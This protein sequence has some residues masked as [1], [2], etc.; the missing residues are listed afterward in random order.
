MSEVKYSGTGAGGGHICIIP[1]PACG[2][3][4]PLMDLTHQLLLRGLT[5]T[6]MVTPKNLSYLNPLLALHSPNVKPLVF[7]FPSHPSLPHGVEQMQDLP[8]S[9]LP[10]IVNALG[11]LYHPLVQWFRAQQSPPVAILSDIVLSSW[12]VNLASHLNIPNICFVP[13][14]VAA[15]YFWISTPSFLLPFYREA[16]TMSMQSEGLVFNSFKELE[17]T[18]LGLIKEKFAKHCRVW[19]VGPLPPVK[20]GDEGLN[21]RGGATSIPPDQVISWLDSCKVDKSVVYI[22]FGTQ[23]TLTKHQMKAVA[24]ALEESGVRFIWAVKEPMKRAE[25]GDDDQSLIPHGFEDRVKG[26][27]LV[28]K[29]WVPQLTILKHRAVGSYFTHCGWNSALEAIVA[30]VLLLAWPMQADHFQITRLLADE[31]G[32]AIRVCKGLR[33]VPDATKLARIFVES[34]TVGQPQRVRAME[35]QKTALNAI[36]E[37]GSSYQALDKVAEELTSFGCNRTEM[38]KTIRSSL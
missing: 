14:N 10:H 20:V 9:F 22:G 13:F 7:P 36:K 16:F 21:E 15:V 27:G 33:S 2:H 30:G 37:G 24:S 26:Q 4:L 35:L 6:I 3:I 19:G 23:I 28:I 12:T 31:V 34:T 29:G 8:I 32:A 38:M 11:K 5:V 17:S 18:K 25:D 1:F